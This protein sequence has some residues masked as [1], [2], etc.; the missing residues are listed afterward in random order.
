MGRT[1]LDLA[2][3]MQKLPDKIEAGASRIVVSVVKAIDR[4]VV[5]HTPVDITTAESNWQASL[6]SP[7]AF[8]LPAIYPGSGGSTASESATAA[9]AHV[10]R[11]LADKKPGEAVFLSNLLDY[12]VPLNNG[13]SKQEPR[14]F[15]ERATLVGRL[16]AKRSKLEL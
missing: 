1:L 11:T 4:D 5:A 2:K 10:D 8:E 12:I 9:I 7:A 6:N 16:T 13:T 3:D 14:G 15:V